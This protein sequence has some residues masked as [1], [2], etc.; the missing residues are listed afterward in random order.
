[1]FQKI[2]KR[3]T[4]ITTRRCHSQKNKYK[5]FR[6]TRVSAT[7]SPQVDQSE[8]ILFERQNRHKVSFDWTNV[9]VEK[10]ISKVVIYMGKIGDETESAWPFL[11]FTE[12]KKIKCQ[13]FLSSK[14]H[15][16]FCTEIARC[17]QK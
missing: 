16:N 14:G 12:G 3:A 4:T 15:K 8:R 17:H 6:N 7:S 10:T 2:H 9:V 5:K 11:S 13:T 1:L